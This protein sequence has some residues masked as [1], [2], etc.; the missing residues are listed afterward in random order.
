MERI[1]LLQ[2]KRSALLIAHPGHEIRVLGWMTQARPRVH[3][4]TDGS[5]RQ[6]KSRIASTR[7]ILE[8]TSATIGTLFGQYPDRAIYQAVL[9]RDVELFEGLAQQLADDLIH[10]EIELVVGDAAEGVV[11]THD[12][13]RGVVNRALELAAEI[14]G[15]P[16]A[17]L[18]FTLEGSPAQKP[19]NFPQPSIRLRLTNQLWQHKLDRA[20][21]YVELTSEVEA[22]LTSWG[23]EAFRQECLY[24]S[25][26]FP[27]DPQLPPHPPEY[28]RLGEQLV[29][30][31]VYPQVV[32][33][34]DHVLPILAA[35]RQ[36]RVAA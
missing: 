26:D 11:M 34:R 22:A 15:E 9:R 16:I 36:T 5:G 27:P 23:T 24:S 14:R 30:A 28:E 2:F 32:R 1:D 7:S 3:I 13:W 21:G 25:T 12:L 29:T 6:G 8:Q 17:S 18:E 35:L 31:G 19:A 4:L 10:H 33:Y 20:R